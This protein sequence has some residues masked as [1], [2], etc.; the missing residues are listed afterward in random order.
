MYLERAN[1]GEQI[2]IT[3]NGKLLATISPPVNKQLLAK[4]QLSKL[5]ETA[6]IYDVV[7]PIESDWNA[8]A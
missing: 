1:A 5:A 6:K 8:L 2:S 3:T 4:E 7:T